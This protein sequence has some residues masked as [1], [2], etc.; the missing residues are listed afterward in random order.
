MRRHRI[1]ADCP[2]I[3][4]RGVIVKVTNRQTS[5]QVPDERDKNSMGLA[6]NWS[7]QP[8][9]THRAKGKKPNTNNTG[10]PCMA[11]AF[12]SGASL[13]I[14]EILEI[15]FEIHVGIKTSDLVFITVEHQCFTLSREKAIFTNASLGCL[16][17]TGMTDL[18][19]NVS[20]KPI[21]KWG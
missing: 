3:C 12:N 21:F 2:V 15:L 8:N 9:Q 20:V 5:T 13:E 16:R 19:V 1:K 18:R 14:F 10:L 6:V 4:R 7:C 11:T 17:P